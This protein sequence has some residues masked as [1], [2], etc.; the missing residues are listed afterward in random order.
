[1]LS[2]RKTPTPHL[3]HNGLQIR[4]WHYHPILY[5]EG[6]RELTKILGLEV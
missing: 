2:R 3:E 1:M 4:L 6:E 5:Q